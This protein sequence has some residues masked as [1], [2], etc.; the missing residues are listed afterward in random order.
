MERIDAIPLGLSTYTFESTAEPCCYSVIRAGRRLVG[1]VRRCYRW[2][3]WTWQTTGMIEEWT[4]PELTS[5]VLDAAVHQGRQPTTIPT[6]HR[7]V[8]AC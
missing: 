1:E 6:G 5:A 4:S 2:G 8:P 3:S 7:L